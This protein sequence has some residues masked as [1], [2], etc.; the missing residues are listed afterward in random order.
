MSSHAISLRCHWYMWTY[1]NTAPMPLVYVDIREHRVWIYTAHVAYHMPPVSHAIGVCG[2][3]RTPR[4]LH[5][6]CHR[7][8]WPQATWRGKDIHRACCVPYA[9]G[10]R[11]RRAMA[12]TP[13]YSTEWIGHADREGDEA[14]VKKATLVYT[15]AHH[16]S[17]HASR[18][19][20]G[21]LPSL[22]NVSCLK[23][24]T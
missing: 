23:A 11:H 12:D 16:G 20:S 3:T 19:K 1:A 22:Y 9:T 18:K 5:S 10:I 2:H 8:M 15:F 24:K 17:D 14:S 13:T 21:G 7:C 6:I 4:M